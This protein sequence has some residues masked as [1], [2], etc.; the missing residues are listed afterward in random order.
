MYGQ[1][2][3]LVPNNCSRLFS[4]TTMRVFTKQSHIIGGTS[5]T[6]NWRFSVIRL[7]WTYRNVLGRPCQ[8]TH[9]QLR[10]GHGRV[11]ATGTGPRAAPATATLAVLGQTSYDSTRWG[12]PWQY[13]TPSM[14]SA[15]RTW[16]AGIGKQGSRSTQVCTGAA[17]LAEPEQRK[18]TQSFCVR[19]ER[20]TLTSRGG[21]PSGQSLHDTAAALLLGQHRHRK[22][23]RLAEYH[24]LDVANGEH[25]TH[26]HGVVLAACQLQKRASR[27]ILVA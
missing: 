2:G 7:R 16:L 23:P 8:A 4:R 15:S 14:K 11:P 22:L 9:A 10:C 6:S 5:G 13:S 24:Q 3:T 19:Q 1:S 17:M 21:L 27:G 12:A 25:V 26:L 20:S 18:S